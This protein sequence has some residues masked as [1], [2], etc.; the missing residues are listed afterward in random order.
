MKGVLRGVNSF[1][2]VKHSQWELHEHA[3]EETSLTADA[4]LRGVR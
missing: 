3:Q 2:H 1:V 4:R